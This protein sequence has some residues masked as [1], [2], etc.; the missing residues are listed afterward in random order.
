MKE[1]KQVGGGREGETSGKEN[2]I[3]V[4][5]T[6]YSVW[7][8]LRSVDFRSE[9]ELEITTQD[10]ASPCIARAVTSGCKDNS[11]VTKHFLTN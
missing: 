9:T 4:I 7:M 1:K 3:I 8:L 6:Q 10:F 5:K 2:L 11:A